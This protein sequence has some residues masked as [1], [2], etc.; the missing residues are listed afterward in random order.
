MS[1]A[2]SETGLRL[3]R[4]RKTIV[5]TDFGNNAVYG[6]VDSRDIPGAQSAQDVAEAIAGAIESRS[7]DVYTRPDGREL[8]VKY[9]REL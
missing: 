1:S 6:G 3:M 8:V 5:A 9:F 2:V 4:N 7:A